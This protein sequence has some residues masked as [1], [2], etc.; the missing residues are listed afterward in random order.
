MYVV[1]HVTIWVSSYVI[2]IGHTEVSNDRETPKDIN[3]QENISPGSNMSINDSGD[4]SECVSAAEGSFHDG[5]AQVNSSHSYTDDKNIIGALEGALQ[6]ERVAHANLCVELE[7]ERNAAATAAD[8]AMAMILRLQEEKASIEMEARQFQRMV[9]EKSTF[10]AE[11]MNIMTE[12]LLRREREKYFLEKEVEAYRQM[13]FA[14][15]QLD[16][17]LEDTAATQE[18]GACSIMSSTEKAEL[19]LQKIRKSFDQEQ[20]GSQDEVAPA[21][22]EVMSINCENSPASFDIMSLNNPSVD[23]HDIHE[24]SMKQAGNEG[25]GSDNSIM[26][27]D[28]GL[29]SEQPLGIPQI[30]S[31]NNTIVMENDRKGLDIKRS[32]SDTITGFQ[33]NSSAQPKNPP[34]N[35]RRKSMSSFDDERIK[36]DNEVGWLRER[37]KFVQK[38]RQ[39]LNFSTMSL[40]GGKAQLQ[41]LE[42]I[43]IQLKKIRRLRDPGKAERQASLPPLSSKV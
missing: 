16:S 21:N 3:L 6:E 4:T 7:K 12:I 5:L 11:E 20:L 42:D 18:E 34:S 9:E 14:N 35:S 33:E 17:D 28:L 1:L 40:E 13:I 23:E 2:V 32:S 29:K 15:E 26:G 8:E 30:S 25:E 10:D 31:S 39:R 19:M 37:L 38:G 24:K 36:I 41:L 22:H 43:A 27:E